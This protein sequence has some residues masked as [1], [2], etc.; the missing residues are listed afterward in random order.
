MKVGDIIQVK[1]AHWHRPGQ[2]GLLVEDPFPGGVNRGK[3]FRVLF[4][5]GEEKTVIAKHMEVISCS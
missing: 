1:F 5:D 2:V 3:A 4:S